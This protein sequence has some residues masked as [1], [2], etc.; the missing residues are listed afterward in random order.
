MPFFFLVST[1]IFSCLLLLCRLGGAPSFPGQ[2]A[3]LGQS[4]KE[5]GTVLRVCLPHPFALRRVA[6]H[7]IA[8]TAA[9][10]NFS[11][12]LLAER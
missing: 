9:G 11:F 6:L 7:L 4:G 8:G 2:P 5:I 1:F 10:R 12:S 3:S